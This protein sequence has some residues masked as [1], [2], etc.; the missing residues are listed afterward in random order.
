MPGRDWTGMG[1]ADFDTTADLGALFDLTP[2]QVR[3]DP[4]ANTGDLLALIDGE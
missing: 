3:P 2:S 4:S 1:P